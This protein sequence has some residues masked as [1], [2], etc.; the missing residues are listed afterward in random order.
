MRFEE[1]FWRTRIEPGHAFVNLDGVQCF[2]NFFFAGY[3]TFTF[4][5]GGDLIEI[6]RIPF[7]GQASLNG[8]DAV[9][10]RRCGWGFG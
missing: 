6:K 3:D 8:A 5:K 7:D 9:G 4:Q 1:G 2:L 10:L